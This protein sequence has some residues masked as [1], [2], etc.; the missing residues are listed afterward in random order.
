MHTTSPDVQEMTRI[1][2]YGGLQGLARITSGMGKDMCMCTRQVL[3]CRKC[4]GSHDVS[5][6]GL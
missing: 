4:K 1:I 2:W 5:G 6:A 3:M